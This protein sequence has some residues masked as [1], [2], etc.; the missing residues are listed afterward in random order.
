M[1]RANNS[2]TPY[3][4]SATVICLSVCSPKPQPNAYD[5][6]AAANCSHSEREQHTLKTI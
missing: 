2:W 3:Y 5:A 4:M 6:S 1:L